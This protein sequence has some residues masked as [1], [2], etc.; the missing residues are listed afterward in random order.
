MQPMTGP[1]FVEAYLRPFAP[2]EI[3]PLI[4]GGVPVDILFRLVLQSVGDLQN[5]HPL[6]RGRR[7]GSPE[8]VPML[9]K[10][11]E[12]QEGGIMRIVIRREK[13]AT[14]AFVV[15]NTSHAPELRPLVV[16]IYRQLGLDLSEREIEVVY[17]GQPLIQRKREIPVFT[18]PDQRALG[19]RRRDSGAGYRCA[20]RPRPALTAGAR[21]G[22]AAG[23]GP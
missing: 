22:T 21:R 9:G 12:L 2:S 6:A 8:Y 14:R 1:Q 17:G 7:A 18:A 16:D 19:R 4:Q 15:F 11:R 3:V 5:T 13:E 10:L 20:Q 23:R